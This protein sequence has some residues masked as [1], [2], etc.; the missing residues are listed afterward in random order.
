MK[1]SAVPSHTRDTIHAV[2]ISLVALGL[3]VATLQPDFGGPEDTPKF[4]FLGYV[5]GTAH[6]PGYPLYVLLSHLFVKVPIGTIAY[7]ANLFSAV[8]AAAACGLSYLIA[9]RI[10]STPWPA[11]CAAL[12]LA[13]G[14]SFWRNAV[15]AEVYSLAAVMAAL[16]IALLLDW[17]AR[18]GAGRLLAAVA[19]IGLGFGNHMTIVGLAPACVIYV[20]LRNRRV[21][22]A[23]VVAAAAAILLLCVSQYGFIIL[24]SI[25]GA[26]YLES[27]AGSLSA[28]L[29]VMTAEDYAS[30][31]FAFTPAT[32]LTVKVPATAAVIGHE[33]GIVGTALL[34]L[35]LIVA[36]RR[37]SS[38]AA[39]VVGAALGTLAMVVNLSGDLQG[40][41][42]PAMV[43]LWPLAALG[44]D[45]IV[46]PARAERLAQLA[47][48]ALAIVIAAAMPVANVAANYKEA[49]QSQQRDQGRFFRSLHAQLPDGAAVVAEDYFSDMA[50][51]YLMF[52][53]EG[54]PDRGIGPLGFGLGP[55]RDALRMG[56]RVFA[57]GRAA[58]FFGAEGLAFERTALTGSPIDQWIQELP[59]GTVIAGAAAYAAVPFELS[60]LARRDASAAL[61]VRP[62]TAFAFVAGRS[63][64]ARRDGETATS[65]TVNAET[66]ESRLPPVPGSLRAIGDERGARV[67]LAGREIA[68]VD[69]GLAVGAFRPD[70]TFWRALEFRSG[71]SLD[72][73]PESS[74]FEL[75][76]QAACVAASTA[77]WTD[78]APVFSTGSWLA[79][80][81][82]IGSVVIETHVGE[83][84]GAHSRADEVLG[85][86]TARSL[87]QTRTTDGGDL[88]V[89]EFTRGPVGRPVFHLALDCVP[90]TARAR[91]R[92]GGVVSTV[93]MCGHKQAP[94]FADGGSHA[95]LRPDFESEAY[96]GAG[97]HDAERTPTGR[98]RRGDE[99]AT[100][101]LPL[102]TAYTYQIA[103]DIVF[104]GS[105]VDV[106]LNGIAAASCDVGDRAPCTVNLS[107][108]AVR[109]GVNALTLSVVG[110]AHA[111]PSR[112]PLTLQGARIVRRPT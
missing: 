104:A 17:G 76:G 73:P 91:V 62:F 107:S 1:P 67:E 37:R 71:E 38:D 4:Q 97:W 111:E 14:A 53:G 52:T 7:R 95:V 10:G 94:L 100:L 57:F 22:T 69:M 105:R 79:T 8:M 82:P 75:K 51:R 99:R 109:D 92:S 9:R 83:S 19:A 84:C 54:G 33:L 58:A 18:G 66:L 49:D 93:E 27:R 78:V 63:G 96:F 65:L 35:G 103:L 70:G 56:R 44:V 72:V 46:A 39:L 2:T 3:F 30:N 21:L 61:R 42:T 85:A 43:F 60:A 45:A 34:A 47:R 89:T 28:L 77:E 87:G 55:V 106:A 12:G 41:I 29:R 26:P 108:D 20:L 98:V 36:A 80:F 68:A 59:R 32:V 90:R 16:T 101:L 6:P 25:Q 5:L 74:L 81:P 24:R 31:R 11:A 13:A 50:L 88:L 40:F 23:R 15:F 64:V 112:P 102:T 86:G 48:R 110:S